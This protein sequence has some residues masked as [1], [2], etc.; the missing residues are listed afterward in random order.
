M[1]FLT[2]LKLMLSKRLFFDNDY[3]YPVVKI[4]FK[5]KK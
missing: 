5:E 3:N 2:R 4:L 1:A